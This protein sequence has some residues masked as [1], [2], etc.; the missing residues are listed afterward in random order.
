[1]VI[2]GD[3]VLAESSAQWHRIRRLAGM[4][5][6]LGPRAPRAWSGDT[7]PGRARPRVE[8]WARGG[9]VVNLSTSGQTLGPY[10]HPVWAALASRMCFRS[11]W[12]WVAQQEGDSW[13]G[14]G[15]WLS[16]PPSICRCEEILLILEGRLFCSYGDAAE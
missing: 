5:C 13:V 15:G 16:C 14:E 6:H 4:W 9:W 11:D 2:G 12:S 3:P 7:S 1:M 10:G 8:L